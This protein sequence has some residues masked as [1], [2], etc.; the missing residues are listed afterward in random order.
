[1]A[2]QTQKPNREESNN[3]RQR[4]EDK[5]F[6]HS[7][8]A[9][10][11]TDSGFYN[12]PKV[13]EQGDVASAEA[14]THAKHG[15]ESGEGARGNRRS[16]A[17]IKDEIHRLMDWQKTIDPTGIQVEVKDGVVTLSGKVNSQYEKQ[18]AQNITENVLGIRQVSNLLKIQGEDKT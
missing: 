6:D 17:D 7:T 12:D 18:V 11:P 5:E 16:D 3:Q 2:E 8:Y 13:Y 9:P 4:D 15:T 1:M 14:G 10:S